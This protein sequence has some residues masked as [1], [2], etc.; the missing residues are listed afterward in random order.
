M[1]REGGRICSGLNPGSKACK[2]MH[3]ALGGESEKPASGSDAPQ[4]SFPGARVAIKGG[5]GGTQGS[6]RPKGD[7]L[8]SRNV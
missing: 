5:W 2:K 7:R 6:S 1:G 4:E 3:G 8:G